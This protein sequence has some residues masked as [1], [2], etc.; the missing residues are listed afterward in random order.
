MIQ[1][2]DKTVI[3]GVDLGFQFVKTRN[4]VFENGCKAM[5]VEPSVADRTM[6]ISGRYYKVGEGRSGLSE[7]MTVG[8]EGRLLIYAGIAKEMRRQGL[9]KAKIILAVGLPFANYGAEK[10]KLIR[11]LQETGDV[12]FSYER[13]KYQLHIKRV[14]VFPQCYAAIAPRLKNMQGEYL[15]VDIGSKTVDLVLVKDGIPNESRSTSI[16]RAIV[17]WIRHIQAELQSTYGRQ[18]PENEIM[19]VMTEEINNLPVDIAK[20]IQGLLRDFVNDLE[21]NITE[22]GYD[23]DYT[24][25]IYVGGGASIARKYNTKKRSNVAYDCD[26][27]AN[28]KGYE[29]LAEQMV[30]RWRNE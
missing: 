11:Y 15:I 5:K 13:E 4:Y 21:G 22:L 10:K 12:R 3:V 30:K 29:F 20:N 18:I 27:K 1:I 8:E 19:K 7:D 28:A 9:K 24:N 26:I 6:K 14:I 17:K 2:D 23:M 16:E 25:I